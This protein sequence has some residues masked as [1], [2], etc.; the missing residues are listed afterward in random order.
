MQEAAAGVEVLPSTLGGI[1][2]VALVLVALSSE[3]GG[4][5]TGRRQLAGISPCG[6][7]GRLL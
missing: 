1:V 6:G 2:G 4:R 5:N 3:A 7:C